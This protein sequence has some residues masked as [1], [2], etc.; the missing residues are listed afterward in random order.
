LRLFSFGGYGLPLAALALVVF[1]AIECPPSQIIKLSSHVGSSLSD[2]TSL[3]KD[4]R[5][6]VVFEE[7]DLELREYI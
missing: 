3:K 4:K 7:L 1:G 5:K 2:R 6:K